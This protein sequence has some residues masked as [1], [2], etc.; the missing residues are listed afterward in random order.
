MLGACSRYS[1][2]GSQCTVNQGPGYKFS[3]V[4][5]PNHSRKGKAEQGRAGLPS[6]S[7]LPFRLDESLQTRIISN[8]LHSIKWSWDV[9]SALL[10]QRRLSLR[11]ER[12]RFARS[13]FCASARM[14]A[15][16]AAGW[17]RAP[18]ARWRGRVTDCGGLSRGWGSPGG[19]WWQP[20]VLSHTQA[21]GI[22]S[23]RKTELFKYPFSSGALIPQARLAVPLLATACKGPISAPAKAMGDAAPL[24]GKVPTS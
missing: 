18:R 23:Y 7:G 17:A 10:P 3:V 20:R 2:G 9:A 19:P 24:Q 12:Q 1:G 8:E 4:K 21:L 16:T 5:P 6:S 13:P 11:W 22:R 15:V 14:L